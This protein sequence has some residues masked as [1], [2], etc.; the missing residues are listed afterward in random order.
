MPKLRTSLPK[1]QRHRASG[2]A[3]VT[4]YGRDF[5]LGPYGTKGSRAEYD[6]LVG[7]WIAAGRPSR[8]PAKDSDITVVELTVA[9]LR[10]AEG[11][12]Q[13][14]G[15]P[16]DT[17]YQIRR[18][19]KL[20]CEKYGRTVA[21]EF[22]PLAL[23]AFQASLIDRDLSRKTVNHFTSA[24][25]RMFR[26]AVTKELVPAATHQ[27]LVAVP[28]I[29]K[30]R[31]AVRETLPVRPV[32]DAVVAATLPHLSSVVADMVR[33][34]RLTG[35]RP[36]EVCL[37]RPMDVDR[38]R[39]IWHYQPASHKTQHLD[40]ERI[41]FVGPKAQAVL[42]PYLLR[43]DDAYCF[44]PLESE[45]RRLEARN[46]ARTTPPS[47][48]NVPGSN[49][50]LRPKWKPTGHYTNDSYNRA[51]QRACE[52]AFGMPKALRR[53]SQKL[54]DGE[55]KQLQEQAAL[56]RAQHCW[57][58]NQLRHAAATEVRRQYGLEAAQVV[59]GHSKADVTQVYAERDQALAAEIMHK[60]G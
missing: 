25:R 17:I 14:N 33:F 44:S 38:S 16:T 19:C 3:V 47:C 10:F 55:R 30:G 18:A 26:W 5:Y 56:W 60:I 39:E 13:K 21:A 46:A 20:A 36:S 40:I 49:R 42:R 48:G 29:A 24:V 22:G 15:T 59:L 58:P 4:L 12:Y 37:L 7:E 52:M 51:I 2:Q 34:Q 41:I 32:E 45:K 9:Y 28:N 31:T 23:Q 27:A 53:I 57:S 54:P 1:Y 43:P 35:C 50:K 6:R 11:Y 8:R